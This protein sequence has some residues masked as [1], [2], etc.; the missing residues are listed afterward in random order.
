MINVYFIS[1]VSINCLS[2]LNSFS[3]FYIKI[4]ETDNSDFMDSYE[5][6]IDVKEAIR[7]TI[8]NKRSFNSDGLA[9]KEDSELDDPE[10]SDKAIPRRQ[11]KVNG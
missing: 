8:K 2:V 5:D 4:S 10:D 1:E 6:D 9:E 7:C 11:S 3:L